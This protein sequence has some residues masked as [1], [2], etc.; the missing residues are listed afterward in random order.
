VI[1][2]CQK[3]FGDGRKDIKICVL[4]HSWGGQVL[5]DELLLSSSSSSSTTT[6]TSVVGVGMDAVIISNACTFGQA[7]LSRASTTLASIL[8]R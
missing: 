1:A 5:L 6:T 2:Y 3:E 7:T 8:G 4:G